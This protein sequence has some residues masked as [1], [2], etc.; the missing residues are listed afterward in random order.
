MK[1][2]KQMVRFGRTPNE[3]L[4]NAN[5]SLKAKGLFAYIESKPDDWEFSVE[6]LK[7]QL[8]ESTGAITAGLHELEDSGF[9]KRDKHHGKDGKWEIDY[10]LYD[11]PND[12]DEPYMEN[13]YM[14]EQY[15]ENIPNNIQ[16]KNTKKEY[17]ESKDIYTEEDLKL[18]KELQDRILD[19]FPNNRI[20]K[21]SNWIKRT[22]TE[23]NR[24]VRIDGRNYTQII[25]AITFAM[26]DSFWCKNIWSG[27]K[28]RKH[29]DLLEANAREK[30][31]KNGTI[32]I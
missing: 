1:I 6:S 13:P 8:K 24:M 14:D 28:L 19:R 25:R 22:A 2:K 23:I 3:L 4:N 12:V 32:V 20:G 31:M 11:R 27:A 17:K 30:F 5:I 9:L 16:R 7:H 18:A 10:I 21:D 26:N 15:M 29:Y